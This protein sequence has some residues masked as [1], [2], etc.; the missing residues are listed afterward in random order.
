MPAAAWSSW[1]CSPARRVTSAGCRECSISGWRRTVP[2]AV[3]GAS[4][5]IASYGRSGVQ[6][7]RSLSTTLAFRSSRCRFV[8]N[9]RS[10]EAETSQRVDRGAC[11]GQLRRLAAGR[12]AGVQNSDPRGVACSD[13]S[14]MRAGTA[15]AASW[16]H[17]FPSGIAGKVFD[18][19]APGTSERT[20]RKDLGIQSTCPFIGIRFDGQIQGRLRRVYVRD[21]LGLRLAERCGTT[22]PKAMEAC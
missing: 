9:I 8:R 16:T 2:V 14:R 19:T 10:R 11:S 21:R 6:A 22:T 18:R 3:Q 13:E 17:Q 7:R 20:R 5:R 1:P 4:T 15:A 12:R